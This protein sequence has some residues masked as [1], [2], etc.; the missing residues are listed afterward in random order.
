MKSAIRP[1]SARRTFSVPY[2][3]YCR[4]LL[5]K[6]IDR[7]SFT[8]CAH[9]EPRRGEKKSERGRTSPRART[10]CRGIGASLPAT[11]R[12]AITPGVFERPGIPEASGHVRRERHVALSLPES[13]A[14]RARALIPRMPRPVRARPAEDDTGRERGAVVSSAV[15]SA[16]RVPRA[17]PRV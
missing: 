14:A 16:Q 8:E 2:K 4:D 6:S 9:F 13:S 1:R 7:F 12:S 15:H 11:H 10:G 3:A 17:D 5:A